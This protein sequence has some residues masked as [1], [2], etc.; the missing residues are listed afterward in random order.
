MVGLQ[1]RDSYDYSRVRDSGAQCVGRVE[2]RHNR[3]LQVT[4]EYILPE[5]PRRGVY[6]RVFQV[7]PSV[8]DTV[9]PG[10]ALT[11]YYLPQDPETANLGVLSNRWCYGI[12]GIFCLVI[13]A[14]LFV[15]WLVRWRPGAFGQT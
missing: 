2:S 3:Y 5:G 15:H 9:K 7:M 4:V 12:S 10:D 8:H 14:V 6:C 13:M 11:V 1:I